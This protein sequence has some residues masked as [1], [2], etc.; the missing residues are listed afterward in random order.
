[1]TLEAWVQ[2]T[3][4]GNAWRTVAL[5]EQGSDLVYG[6]YAGNDAGV[7]S[8]HVNNGSHTMLA[9]TSS[10]PLSAWTHVAGVWDGTTLRLYVNGTQVRSTPLSG[11]ASQADQPLYV[12]GNAVWGEWF[13]GLIDDVRVYSRALSAAEVQARATS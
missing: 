5:K 8:V 7:P 10:L 12:G 13:Q 2:P 6:L 3:A 4:L 9:G 1:M 11:T